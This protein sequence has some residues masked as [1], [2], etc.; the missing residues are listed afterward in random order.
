TRNTG[1]RRRFLLGFGSAVVNVG[2]GPLLIEGE[3]PTRKRRLMSAAQILRR[4]DG[5]TLTR[6]NVASMLYVRSEDH[7]HW[8]VLRFERYEL[9]RASDGKLVRP[10]RKTGFC[11]GDRYD[12][13]P[14]KRL[15]NEPAKA[16]WTHRCGIRKP[17]LLRIREGI[18][19][20][21]GDDYDPHVEG[22]YVDLTRVPA[23]QYE[24]V[25]RVNADRRLREA[26]YGNNASSI[27]FELGWPGGFGASPSLNVLARCPDSDRCRRS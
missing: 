12:H 20:G 22:Q 2:D 15:A 23:G 21:Y 25:H 10:D 18:S 4:T 7:A 14:K 11:L 9:R 26:D 3:R 27:L 8:H 6:R 1:G 24:L 19:V 16:V 17:G 13:D 5:S